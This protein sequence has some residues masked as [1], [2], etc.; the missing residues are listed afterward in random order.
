M[1]DKTERKMDIKHRSAG[2]QL[3]ASILMNTIYAMQN[4][5]VMLLNSMLGPFSFLIVIDFISHGALLS[6]AITGAFIS[7]MVSA[8]MAL[9]GDLSHLKNDMRFQDIV[10]SSPTPA[11]TYIVGMGISELIYFLPN[12]V[13]LSILMLLF[14]PLTTSIILTV[15]IVMMIMFVFAIALS[16]LLSTL[17]TDIV[18]SW[19]FTGLVSTLLSTI[20]PVYY[21]ITYIPIPYRYI[22]YISPTTYAAQ[23]AQA[24]IGAINIS[25]LNLTADWLVLI[26]ASIVLLAVAVK[27]VRWREP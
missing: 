1:A 21:P 17:S 5:P 24:A 6:V 4:F 15:I 10:V 16:F 26:L 3:L 9:Q 11:L 27:K 12:I 23:I 8:G 22:A 18:Q 2:S 19:A 20:P 7:T 14:V 25:Q 13:L